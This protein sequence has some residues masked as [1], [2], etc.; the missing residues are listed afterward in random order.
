LLIGQ[1]PEE[2]AKAVEPLVEEAGEG[3]VGRVAP[4]EPRPPVHD[5]RL[6][7]GR[8]EQLFHV[9][10]DARRLVGQDR[11]R[12]HAMPRLLETGADAR[13]T[14]IVGFGPRVA[15]RHDGAA[16]ASPV[17]R[18]MLVR[19]HRASLR[20][21]VSVRL[22]L[23]GARRAA[24]LTDVLVLLPV[25]QHEEEPL[26]DGHRL[27][28]AGAVE[29]GRLERLVPLGLPPPARRTTHHGA[30]GSIEPLTVATCWATARPL[31]VGSPRMPSVYI[32]TYGCQM[33]LADTE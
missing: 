8:G 14:R 28:A 26:P 16:D 22:D 18:V 23:R 20:R 15:H 13:T 12:H 17:A 2:L 19:A 10:P 6:D 9:R 21:L 11:V 29:Q 3:L 1:H 32:E 4:G 30:M 24:A 31:C 25:E 7:L 33:N 27:A 5:H